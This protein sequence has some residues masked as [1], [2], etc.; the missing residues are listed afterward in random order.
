MKKPGPERETAAT[1]GHRRPFDLGSVYCALFAVI[2]VS[3]ALGQDAPLDKVHVPP[4][5]ATT[6][7]AA[8]P[9]GAEAPAVSGP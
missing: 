2:C 1:Q 3:V 7:G 5:A 8:E 9:A 6:P 4:P